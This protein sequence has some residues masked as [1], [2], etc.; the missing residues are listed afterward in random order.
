MKQSLIF[1]SIVLLI[2]ACRQDP[3]KQ[4]EEGQVNGD[5]YESAEIGW[6]VKIPKG[7]TVVRQN[8]EK[9]KEAME[10]TAGGEIDV[11]QLKQLITFKKDAFNLFASTSEPFEEEYPG[12]FIENTKYIQKLIYDTYVNQGIKADTS[13]GAALI[14]D[15]NFSMLEFKIY[16]K[17]GNLIMTQKLYSRLINGFQFGININYNNDEDRDILMDA[18]MNSK[19]DKR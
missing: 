8:L 2:V 9:G 13:S 12:E 11:S 17:D 6:S 1:I 10:K 19:F 3:N 16:G 4:I 18:V 15:L 14:D 5:V 7:W